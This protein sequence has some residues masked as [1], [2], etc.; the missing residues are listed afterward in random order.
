M[1]REFCEEIEFVKAPKSLESG[2]GIS[3]SL[4]KPKIRV[5][6]W[7]SVLSFK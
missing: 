2:G 5:G 7:K 4:R 3:H 1:N 6:G